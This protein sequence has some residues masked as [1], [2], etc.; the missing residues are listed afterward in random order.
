MDPQERFNSFLAYLEDSASL[1]PDQ[2]R[3]IE[4]RIDEFRP[5]QSAY[6][7]VL[8]PGGLHFLNVEDRGI[9]GSI[10]KK[11]FHKGNLRGSR[12]GVG[13]TFKIEN[14]DLF[15]LDLVFS[16]KNNKNNLPG[17]IIIGKVIDKRSDSGYIINKL[18]EIKDDLILLIRNDNNIDKLI[19]SVDQIIVEIYDKSDNCNKETMLAIKK[20]Y[21]GYSIIR[22]LAMVFRNYAFG[23]GSNVLCERIQE[24]LVILY[25]DTEKKYNFEMVK[26][27]L[28]R[29]NLL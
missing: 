6:L 25:P 21:K 17:Q 3:E 7:P 10:I 1:S 2:K 23:I 29:H 11:L 9:C 24:L 19:N 26:K 28:Q 13:K 22:H 18:K 5:Y 27:D 8:F 12:S 15:I 20:D 4:N 14:P 16:F